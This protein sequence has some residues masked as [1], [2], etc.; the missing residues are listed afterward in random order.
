MLIL[1][2]I[3]LAVGI[4]LATQ[5]QSAGLPLA[6]FLGVSLVHVPGAMIHFD[7][8]EW[9]FTRLGFEQT[10]IGMVAFLAGVIV[11][12]YAR[13]VRRSAGRASVSQMQDLTPQALVRLERIGLY[14]VFIGIFVFFVLMRLSISAVSAILLTLS[15]LIVVGVCL[16]LWVARQQ[17]KSLKLWLT[18]ALLPLLPLATVIQIAFVS[19]SV[20]WLLTVGSFLFAQSR[21]R[22]GYFLL[23][24]VLCF[25]GLSIFVNYVAARVEIRQLTWYQGAS[26]DDRF[27]RIA[28]TFRNFE[29][30][31][32]SKSGQRTAIDD[33]LNH[34]FFVGTA[35]ARLESGAVNYASGAALGEMIIALI[36]R[37]VWPDKPVVGGGKTVIH[38]FTGIE[39]A[40]GTSYGAGQVFEF[41]VNFGTLGV[42]G[43]FLLYGWLYGWMDLSVMKYLRLGDQRLLTPFLSCVALLK[44]E[45]N[46]LEI[47]VGVAAAVITGYCL[48]HLFNRY[49]PTRAAA[50]LLQPIAGR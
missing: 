6:Y 16:R 45:G 50:N 8:E 37:A 39:V 48:R 10:V 30:F 4:S 7:S 27:Q 9:D 21:R 49:A 13:L 20:A 28:D 5:R 38:D 14:Y 25:V 12:R 43:G 17:R 46:L 3:W 44:P 18:I 11:A 35:V 41:Y 1:L 31:D 36:P 22:L 32:G 23:A 15:S 19:F 2:L 26:L 42:I 33:R 47:V 24:P 40:E 34:N 29:W